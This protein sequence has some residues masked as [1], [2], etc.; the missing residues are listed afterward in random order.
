MRKQDTAAGQPAASLPCRLTEQDEVIVARRAA[1]ETQRAIAA[2]L[3]IP[4]SQVQRAEWRRD[5]DAEG[6]ALLAACAD[7]VEG[8]E[9]IGALD[10]AAGWVIR[11]HHYRYASHQLTRMS[12]AAAF[13]RR[14]WVGVATR[15]QLAEIDRVLSLL[16]IAWSPID[17]EPRLLPPETPAE[18]PSID[19]AILAEV[20]SRVENL[21]R[22]SGCGNIFE[23]NPA[24]DTFEYVR[25]RL[26][27]LS[28]YICPAERLSPDHTLRQ[29]CT[30]LEDRIRAK[31][32]RLVLEQVSTGDLETVGN[33]VCMP[34]VKLANVLPQDGGGGHEPAA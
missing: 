2:S 8:L 9:R 27:Y 7:S 4:V 12:E 21:E 22:V 26:Q 14:Y 28:G 24:R 5:W 16:G 20:V 32:G 30:I 10:R 15:K 17:C 25:G 19:P 29:R 3:G 1:G 33:I 6:R 31:H 34:G 13:G 18:P 23:S 11:G